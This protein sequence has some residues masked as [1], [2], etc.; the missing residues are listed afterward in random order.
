LPGTFRFCS[1]RIPSATITFSGLASVRGAEGVSKE[2]LRS[3]LRG[4]DTDAQILATLCVLEI[5]PVG[6]FITYGV[7]P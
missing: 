1:G 3:L 6:D 4:L 5:Q 7:G 2:V